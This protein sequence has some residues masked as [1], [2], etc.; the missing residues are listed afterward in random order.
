[1]AKM[2]T[3]EAYM[4]LEPIYTYKN[5]LIELNK[6]IDHDLKHPS[7]SALHMHGSLIDSIHRLLNS[8]STN[9]DE[10]EEN[11]GWWNRKVA[12]SY[13]SDLISLST[14]YQIKFNKLATLLNN[15]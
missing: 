8:Y 5:K 9:L 3:P 2:S 11:A 1:M 15:L 7:K 14:D 4:L 10:I 12:R 6:K 13:R